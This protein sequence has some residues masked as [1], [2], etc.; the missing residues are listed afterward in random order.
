METY[1]SLSDEW[2][3]VGPPDDSDEAQII[4]AKRFGVYMYVWDMWNSEWRIASST[5]LPLPNE[6]STKIAFAAV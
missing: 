5:P 1:E 4:V 6:M 2:L 3:P